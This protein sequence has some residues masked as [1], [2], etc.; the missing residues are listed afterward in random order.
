MDLLQRSAV[1][2]CQSLCPTTSQTSERRSR[3]PHGHPSCRC[4]AVSALVDRGSRVRGSAAAG[5]GVLS[6]ATVQWFTENL[7]G[8]S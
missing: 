5:M 8:G 2:W 4:M 1:A 6:H 3:G 7:I